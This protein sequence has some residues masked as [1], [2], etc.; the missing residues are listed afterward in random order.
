[1]A[2]YSDADRDALHVKSADEAVRIGPP[3]ARLS[4]LNASSIVEAAMRT[5][6]QVREELSVL[7]GKKVSE[8]ERKSFFFWLGGCLLVYRIN[9][10][11]Y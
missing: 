10:L 4:Y 8:N 9:W 5:G 11:C 1:M 6:A 7:A 3:P 2:V